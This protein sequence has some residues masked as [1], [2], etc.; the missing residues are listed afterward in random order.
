MPLNEEQK[1]RGSLLEIASAL[2]SELDGYGALTLDRATELSA[3][4]SET[5]QADAAAEAG[6]HQDV[7]AALM[8]AHGLINR[9]MG[10][11]MEKMG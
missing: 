1:V 2:S 9:V 7:W 8:R 10:D 5:A 4:A 6:K 11:V 3:V